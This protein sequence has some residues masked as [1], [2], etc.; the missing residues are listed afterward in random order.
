MTNKKKFHNILYMYE[1][2]MIGRSTVFGTI[3][4]DLS[5]AVSR[6]WERT[7]ECIRELIE[8]KEE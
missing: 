8:R 6:S 3:R 5:L 4:E 2:V 7:W 1:K